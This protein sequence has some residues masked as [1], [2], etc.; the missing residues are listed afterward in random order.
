[1]T[2]EEILE[3]Y[4]LQSCNVRKLNQVKNSLIRDINFYLRKSDDFQVEVK[5]KL[6]AILYVAWSEAQFIQ[7]VYTPSAFSPSEIDEIKK[8]KKNNGLAEGWKK[9]VELALKKV[10]KWEKNSDLPN[11]RKRLGEIIENYINSP[12]VLRNKVAQGQWFHALNTDNTAENIDLTKKLA[13]LDFVELIKQ[14]EVHKSL[15]LI[16]RDLVQSPKKG[17]HQ[18]YWVRMTA[19]EEYVD[20]TRNWNIESKKSKLSRKPIAILNDSTRY[21]AEPGNA[22]PEALPRL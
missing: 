21:Q 12:S 15:G 5:T 7:I 22:D 4:K 2:N 3:L 11:K 13:E 20:K 10:G 14:F 1:M 9:M 18:N 8:I 6:L 17:F 16:I 19:L